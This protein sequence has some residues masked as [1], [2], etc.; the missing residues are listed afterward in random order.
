MTSPALRIRD[1]VKRF[2]GILA[3]DHVNLQVE[4]NV[5]HALIGPNGAGKTTLVHQLAGT[6]HSNSGAIEFLGHEISSMPI[7]E[8]VRTGIARSYQITNIF[9]NYTVLHN[10]MLAV[11]A[12]SGSSF[13]FWGSP[14][15]EETLV[16]EA[17]TVLATVGLSGREG[18]Q[19]K[20]LSYGEQRRIEI[21]LALAT[22]PKLL[23][24]DEPLAGMG[25]ADAEQMVHLIE[26]LKKTVTIV[27][28][29]HDMGAVFRL[30]D[31]ISVLVYGKVIATDT[32]AAIR[33]SPVVRQAYLGDEV[34]A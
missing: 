5:I 16:Q 18:D 25:A 21:G 20:S 24:L 13:R 23:L 19:A 15:G 12:R 11:Q 30:A 33:N 29:E 3:T 34:P 4:R 17:R 2:G 32:P 1:L 7:H 6:L 14:M 10:V 31:F 26:V 27:L 22:Q 9:P 8:R 28:I